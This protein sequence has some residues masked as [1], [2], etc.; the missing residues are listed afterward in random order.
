MKSNYSF[1][2]LSAVVLGS[3]AASNDP[4]AIWK[5]VRMSLSRRALV[6]TAAQIQPSTNLTWAPC[7]TSGFECARLQ[8][9]IV[10]VVFSSSRSCFFES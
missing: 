9:S 5:T 8:V 4:E 6:L 7:Y 2:V 3:Q 1:F 10:P